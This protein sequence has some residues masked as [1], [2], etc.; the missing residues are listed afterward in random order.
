MCQTVGIV[1][2]VQNPVS[3]LTDVNSLTALWNGIKKSTKNSTEGERL[4][5]PY[6]CRL[7]CD[8]NPEMMGSAEPGGDREASAEQTEL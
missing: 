4:W 2:T 8:T 7:I 6:M 5:K 3:C 1:L